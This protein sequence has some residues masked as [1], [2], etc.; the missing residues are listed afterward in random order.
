MFLLHGSLPFPEPLV[1]R[2]REACERATSHIGGR[3][4]PQGHRGRA[5]LSSGLWLLLLRQQE[6]W[7]PNLARFADP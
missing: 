6:F 7:N 1:S 5:V 4:T 3:A 2:L